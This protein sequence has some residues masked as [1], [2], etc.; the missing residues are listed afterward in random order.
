MHHKKVKISEE[1]VVLSK[2][3]ISSPRLTIKLPWYNDENKV[4]GIFGCSI[5]LGRDALADSL[6]TVSN[7][8]LLHPPENPSNYI[9]KEI[10]NN[11]LS[12]REISCANLLLS[13]MTYKEIA[14]Q[15]NLSYRTIETY[16]ENLK[17]KLHCRNKT[18]L[19]LKLTEISMR[20]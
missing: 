7:L 17:Q 14:I 20:K 10:N 12:K 8:G 11:Y 9:G 16:I 15:L 19:V 2:G 5:I 3:N 1:D 4:V 6:S 13:G 18:E